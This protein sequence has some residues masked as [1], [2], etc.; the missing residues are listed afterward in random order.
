[1]KKIFFSPKIYSDAW[2]VVIIGFSTFRNVF[3]KRNEVIKTTNISKDRLKE[4]KLMTQIIL[5][6]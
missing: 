5:L 6:L 3:V 4:N 1:M 2:T